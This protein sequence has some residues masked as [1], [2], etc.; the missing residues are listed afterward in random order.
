[1][2]KFAHKAFDGHIYTFDHLHTRELTIELKP[3]AGPVEA[4]VQVLFGCHCFTEAFDDTKHGDHHRYTHRDE[5]RAFD[6]QRYACS[7]QLPALVDAMTQ[8]K[9]YQSAQS[10]T[11]V[12]QIQLPQASG[13]SSYSLF[14]SLEKKSDSTVEAPSATMFIKSAYMR[15]L[16]APKNAPSWRYSAL[17]G[18]NTGVYVPVSTPRPTKKNAG[19]A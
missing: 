1:M 9:V 7:L 18:F 6:L 16:A 11:Y 5:V 8:G 14:F 10:Y 13:H 12:T 17:V 15:D 3:P 4:K 2:T 19:K